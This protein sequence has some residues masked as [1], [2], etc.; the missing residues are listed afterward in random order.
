MADIAALRSAIRAEIDGVRGRPGLPYLPPV[1][2]AYENGWREAVGR[3]TLIIDRI[4]EEADMARAVAIPC[5]TDPLCC[6][7]DGHDGVHLYPDRP[8][9][10]FAPDGFVL[11]RLYSG[12]VLADGTTNTEPIDFLTPPPLSEARSDGA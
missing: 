6:R 10:F 4:F 2:P 8:V 11:V 1:T 7:N 3:C 5:Q 12:G 9:A